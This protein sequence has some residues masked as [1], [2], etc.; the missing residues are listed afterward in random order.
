[1]AEAL[2]HRTDRVVDTEMGG[3]R[4]VKG[5]TGDARP[6]ALATYEWLSGGGMLTVIGDFE[7]DTGSAAT[8][9]AEFV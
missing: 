4:K 7:A 2:G 1:M 3:V 5:G 9:V 6:T 8:G